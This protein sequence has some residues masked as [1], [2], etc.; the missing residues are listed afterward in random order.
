MSAIVF[1]SSN[2]PPQVSLNDESS[3]DDIISI[4]ENEE[5]YQRSSKMIQENN[6]DLL[7]KEYK[8]D[9]KNLNKEII[10]L[11]HKLSIFV[12]KC[13]KL[14]RAMKIILEENDEDEIGIDMNNDNDII[15]S[16]SS[17]STM[18]RSRNI[19]MEDHEHEH[20]TSDESDNNEVSD[21]D[22]EYVNGSNHSL[23]G[24]NNHDSSRKKGIMSSNNPTQYKKW[25]SDEDDI[26]IR[27][28]KRRKT[29]GDFISEAFK[30]L[31]GR[32][33]KAVSNRWWRL[34]KTE[35]NDDDDDDDDDD[36]NDNND[37][38]DHD[39]NSKNNNC[40]IT[41]TQIAKTTTIITT[42]RRTKWTRE[43]DSIIVREWNKSKIDY[44]YEASKYLPGRTHQAIYQRWHENL[45]KYFM[46]TPATEEAEEK[47]LSHQRSRNERIKERDRKKSNK[48]ERVKN[49]YFFA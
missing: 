4:S 22:E 43:E 9:N 47:K 12:R 19:M 38:N 7:L 15:S 45:S 24:P 25:S 1:H 14:K 41:D 16:S 18:K 40:G 5:E 8:E 36:N 33:M 29:E 27:E 11:K 31:P 35:E 10:K 2:N 32:S 6:K 30:Y 3:D 28:Y 20:D 37:S 17:T 46:S 26:L 48:R 42:T 49:R 21:S 34:K 13:Q 23:T 39:D 44:A